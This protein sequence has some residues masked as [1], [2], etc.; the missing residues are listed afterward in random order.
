MLVFCMHVSFLTTRC[1]SKKTPD[2]ARTPKQ[3]AGDCG[4][5]WPLALLPAPWTF[6]DVVFLLA[7]R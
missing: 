7:L 5:A 6:D 1:A 3:L 4:S 2:S